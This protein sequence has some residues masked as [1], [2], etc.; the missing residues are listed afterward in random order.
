MKLKLTK[1]NNIEGFS[2]ALGN[3]GGNVELYTEEGDKLNLKSKLSQLI[4]LN[5]ILCGTSQLNNIKLYIEDAK[6][7]AILMQYI[8]GEKES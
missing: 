3:C 5:T 4:S 2:K 6:D 1:V 8:A 7:A